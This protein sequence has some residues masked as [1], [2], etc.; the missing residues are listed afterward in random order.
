MVTKQ[1]VFNLIDKVA[2][3]KGLDEEGRALLQQIARVESNGNTTARPPVRDDGTR[4]SGARGLFQFLPKTWAGLVKKYPNE[5]TINGIDDPKQQV[6]AAV[7]HTKENEQKLTTALGGHPPTMGQ[8]YLAHF[9]GASGAIKTLK[10][11]PTKRLDDGYELL[12]KEAIE[13]NGPFTDSKGK[14]HKN[15]RLEIKGEEDVLLK[16][17]T[18]GDLIVWSN[19]KMAQPDGYE[20]MSA[21]ERRKYRKD[22]GILDFIPDA[23]GNMEMSSIAM[24]GLAVIALLGV[25]FSGNSSGT[26]NPSPTPSSGGRGK[27]LF[28]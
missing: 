4:A 7:Y 14:R 18:A 2:N 21:E 6:I 24:I 5:L 28:S 27:G 8:L 23:F 26:Q 22:K 16:D 17:F 12:S 15:V 19:R 11:S 25:V 1:E 13:A 9:A 20:L 10:A 3:D